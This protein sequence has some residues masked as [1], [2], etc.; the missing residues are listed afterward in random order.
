MIAGADEDRHRVGDDAVADYALAPDVALVVIESGDGCV[1]DLSG[2]FYSLS[3]VATAMLRDIVTVG[4]DVA[5]TRSAGRYG[6]EEARIA[7]DLDSFLGDM[8]RRGLLQSPRPRRRPGVRRMLAPAIAGLA[9]GA[10]RLARSQRGRARIALT[11][12]RLSFLVAGWNA[13]V[14]AWRRRLPAAQGGVA[15]LSEQSA[16]AIDEAVRHAAAGHVMNVDC[17][18]RALACFALARL[19]GLPATLVVGIDFYPLAG[20]SW[21]ETGSSVIGDEEAHCRR[22]TPA[23]RLS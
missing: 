9:L 11:L 8:E 13:T 22:F 23:F 21:C 15:R 18:E 5:V 14:K 7:A 19:T 6:V 3:P 10:L 17:K 2:S 12:A 16:R 20:H 1:V 4:R